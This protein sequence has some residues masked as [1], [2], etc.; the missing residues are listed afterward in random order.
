ME[1]ITFEK[2]LSEGYYFLFTTSLFNSRYKGGDDIW[3]NTRFNRTYLFNLLG[4]KE[5]QTGRSRQNIFG[6]NVR[7]VF[8]GGDRYSPINKTA[9]LLT[10][11]VVYDESNA[12]S[13]QLSPSFLAHLTTSY[14]IN[15][16]KVSH[17][18]AFKILNATNYQ[19]FFG[20]RYNLKNNKVEEFRQ[21]L[22]IP[23]FRPPDPK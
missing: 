8:Q 12:F 5:W 3:R 23:N 16:K 22:I 14:K 18:I 15:K 9:S 4:G 17:E 20:F 2:Y 13:E 7:L 21:P 10:Q 19:E 11:N 6:I 1:F